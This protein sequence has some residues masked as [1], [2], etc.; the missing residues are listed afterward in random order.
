M[1]TIITKVEARTVFGV[2]HRE[3]KGCRLTS[4][5]GGDMGIQLRYINCASSSAELVLGVAIPS[6]RAFMMLRKST[7]ECLEKCAL[8]TRWRAE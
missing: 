5:E 6:D 7:R 8:P 2:L 1:I 4:C 3:C